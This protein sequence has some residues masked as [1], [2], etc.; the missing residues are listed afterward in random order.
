MA[1]IDR[2][3]QQS[4][5]RGFDI[6]DEGFSEAYRNFLTSR[7][8]AEVGTDGIFRNQ[9]GSRFCSCEMCGMVA[10]T[11][12]QGRNFC[13]YHFPYRGNPFEEQACTEAMHLLHPLIVIA[14]AMARCDPKHPDHVR[15]YRDLYDYSCDRIGVPR[16]VPAQQLEMHIKGLIEERVK[17]A[18][19]RAAAKAEREGRPVQDTRDV[20]VRIRKLANKLSVSKALSNPF[21]AKARAQ[22]PPHPAEDDD[23][24]MEVTA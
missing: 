24:L 12:M 16:P 3:E 14:C 8:R 11:E 9:S 17:S 19:E 20:T 4:G 22:R 18:Q 7:C 5:P 1:F 6:K 21:P 10:T 23:F 2:K 15:A 13:D